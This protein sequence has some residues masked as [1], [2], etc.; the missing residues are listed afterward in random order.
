VD[1]SAVSDRVTT[2]LSVRDLPARRWRFSMSLNSNSSKNPT[3][4]SLITTGF[5]KLERPRAASKV[6]GCRLFASLNPRRVSNPLSIYLC[7]LDLPN[8]LFSRYFPTITTGK[9]TAKKSRGQI[10]SF[11]IIVWPLTGWLKGTPRSG[12]SARIKNTGAKEIRKAS[13]YTIW[14]LVLTQ[15]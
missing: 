12:K 3:A 8:I 10:T 15:S 1:D 6:L 13:Q 2:F 11:S 9:A 4:A 7:H 5:G 14:N